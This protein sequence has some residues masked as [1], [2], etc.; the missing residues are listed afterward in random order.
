MHPRF[1]FASTNC[2]LDYKFQ[3]N[4]PFF[5]ILFKYAQSLETRA[6]T[7]TAFEI[8]KFILN[9]NPIDDPL[10]MVLVMDYYALRC[11]QTDWL[12]KFFEFYGDDRNLKQLPNMLYSY[13]LALFLQEGGEY[14]F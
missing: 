11:R 5:L 7:R 12:I 6:C 1:N 14:S 3:E 2:R 4:R 9:V 10:G 13:A 8:S